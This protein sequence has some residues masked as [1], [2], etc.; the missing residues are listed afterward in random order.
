MKKIFPLTLLT[1]VLLGAGCFSKSE[2]EPASNGPVEI[3]REEI[4]FDARENGLIMS[5]EEVSAMSSIEPITAAD[6]SNPTSLTS[7]LE[8]DMKAWSSAALADVTGGESFG[9]A[10][11]TFANGIFTVVADLGNLTQPAENFVYE[12]WLVKRG[13]AMMLVDLGTVT[14]T[15]KGHALV[16]TSSQDLSE[17]DFFVLTL[18]TIDG[19]ST[20]EEHILEGRFR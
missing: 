17:Y 8:A 16:F 18:E 6:A 15:E 20:A 1:L 14:A 3:D 11:A 12:G 5:Q 7:Y 4:L 10:H 9:L 19:S 2:E 13:E